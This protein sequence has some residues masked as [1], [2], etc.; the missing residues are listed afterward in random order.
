MIRER[1]TLYIKCK[2]MYPQRYDKFKRVA[3]HIVLRK[4]L[5]V[6]Y[7]PY[8]YSTLDIISRVFYCI[9]V[10]MSINVLNPSPEMTL[11]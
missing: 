2:D 3:I 10:Y 4:L 8:L 11:S 6:I 1:I 9:V 7:N 5:Y